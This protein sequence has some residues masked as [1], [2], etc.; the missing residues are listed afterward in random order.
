M[1]GFLWC[2]FQK[3][4]SLVEIHLLPGMTPAEFTEHLL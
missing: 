1:R 3:L 2:F 4:V